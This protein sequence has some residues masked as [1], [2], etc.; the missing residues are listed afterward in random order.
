MNVK[1]IRVSMEESVMILSMLSVVPV[2][3]G[4]YIWTNLPEFIFKFAHD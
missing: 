2:Q 4:E 1:I 3:L